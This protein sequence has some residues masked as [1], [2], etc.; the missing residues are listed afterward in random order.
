MKPILIDD[1]K[2]VMSTSEQVFVTVDGVKLQGYQ[3]AKPLNHEL[4]FW[5]RVKGAC[6]VLFGK[7][8][9]VQYFRDLKEREKTEYVKAKI[10]NNKARDAVKQ[11]VIT[12]ISSHPANTPKK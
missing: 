6:K 10:A 11:P 9:P 3:V 7:A 4:S 12:D 8:I 2:D 5:E 1:L